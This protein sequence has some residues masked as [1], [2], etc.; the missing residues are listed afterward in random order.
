MGGYLSNFDYQSHLGVPFMA[1]R[2]QATAAPRC[3]SP[4]RAGRARVRA[5]YAFFLGTFVAAGCGGGHSGDGNASLDVNEPITADERLLTREELLGKRLFEDQLLS[6]PPGQSCASCHDH[7]AAFQ[8]NA[9]SS[10]API[11][12]GSRPEVFGNRNVPTA[13]YALF[14][15]AFEILPEA[16]EEGGTEYVPTGGQFWDGRA[17]SLSEQA[18]GPFLNP[19]EMNNPSLEVVVAKVRDGD[20]GRLAVSVWGAEAFDEADQTY[21]RIA[22]AI[23]AFERTERFRPFRSKF[24]DVLRGTATFSDREALGFELFKDPEK[25]NCL[26]CHVG[27]T[28]SGRPED[29]L[30]TDFTYDNLGVPRNLLIPD[31]ADPATFDLGL[32]AQEG[33]AETAPVGFDVGS[34]CG[35]F[36]VPTL[37]NIARTAP[38]M[39]NGFFTNL[40]DVVHFYATRDTHPER[41]YPLGADGSVAKFDDLPPEYHANVNTSEPPYDRAFGEE[42]RLTDEEIDAIVAFLETLTDQ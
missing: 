2:A 26:A 19:R 28:E 8:G 17:D 30:F 21:E 3:T 5:W 12:R 25:G 32:C 36:K 15:P 20:Y 42:P 31:N 34:L 38:Y 23:A 41:W 27:D 14:S 33:I 11:A 35:A 1:D 9:G 16:T 4:T 7:Q 22:R 39:H 24:D 13:M 29:W 37:R 10:I 40:R 6:E 18:K